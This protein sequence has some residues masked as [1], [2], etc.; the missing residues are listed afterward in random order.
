MPG[1]EEKV[2]RKNIKRP[3]L[4]S[5]KKIRNRY[6]KELADQKFSNLKDQL[7]LPATDPRDQI[8]NMVFELKELEQVFPSFTSE[9]EEPSSTEQMIPSVI[10]EISIDPETSTQEQRR[11]YC[12]S[13]LGMTDEQIG[14]EYIPK[15]VF[16]LANRP[17]SAAEKAHALTIPPPTQDQI[18]YVAEQIKWREESY[19]PGKVVGGP[20]PL[21]LSD[22]DR[23]FFLKL[24]EKGEPSPELVNLM[25]NLESLDGSDAALLNDLRAGGHPIATEDAEGNLVVTETKKEDAAGKAGDTP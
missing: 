16:Y 17:L 1:K 19:D 15:G 18:D 10:E 13:V 2:A 11:F 9:D 4:N 3:R 20:V 12:R 24:L 21:V 22:R 25:K 6:L 5:R 8:A 7:V 23:D 14:D